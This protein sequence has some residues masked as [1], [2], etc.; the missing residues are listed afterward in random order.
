MSSPLGNNP[1][2]SQIDDGI[3]FAKRMVEEGDDSPLLARGFIALGI[4]LSLKAEEVKLQVQRQ[5]YQ[6]KALNA[7]IRWDIGD[8]TTNAQ[9]L[10]QLN[11]LEQT[12]TKYW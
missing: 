4:G 12:S 9:R 11:P 7:F 1:C 6:R 8:R 5:D 3:A 2:L 10:H